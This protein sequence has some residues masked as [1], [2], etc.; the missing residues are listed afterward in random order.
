MGISFVNMLKEYAPEPGS[1]RRIRE[2]GIS[3]REAG[4]AGREPKRFGLQKWN[5]QERQE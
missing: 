4:G 5:G 2:A 3:A 1:A